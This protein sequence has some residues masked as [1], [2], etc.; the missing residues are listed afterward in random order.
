[1]FSLNLI[2]FKLAASTPSPPPW[3]RNRSSFAR[4]PDFS[5]ICTTVR[6]VLA[7]LERSEI[8]RPLVVP[9]CRGLLQ[10]W[11]SWSKHRQGPA[12]AWLSWRTILNFSFSPKKFCDGEQNV[13]I[14]FALFERVHTFRLPLRLVLHEDGLGPKDAG[15]RAFLQRSRHQWTSLDK[16]INVKNWKF[17]NHNIT[18]ARNYFRG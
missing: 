1:M 12:R 11:K 17:L 16:N 5:N 9:A 15:A 10:T 13:R 4:V 14:M 3:E 2:T 8:W 6:R 7:R 18:W